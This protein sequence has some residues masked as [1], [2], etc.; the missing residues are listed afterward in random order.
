LASEKC[1]KILPIDL[2]PVTLPNSLQYPLAGL[3]RAPM[4]NI[5]S[6]L[7]ALAKLGLIATSAPTIKIVRDIP[8][9]KS[10]MTLPFQDHSPTGDNGWFADGIVSELIAQLSG[11]KALRVSDPQ[12][13]KEFKH[14]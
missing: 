6:I 8:G 7:R 12:A 11:I 13:T 1:K 3:Q 5:D 4:T 9:K 10:V 2:E 14:Y